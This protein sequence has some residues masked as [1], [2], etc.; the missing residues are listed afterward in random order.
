MITC[1]TCSKL[2]DR[3]AR[4]PYDQE[5]ESCRTKHLHREERVRSICA[6]FLILF[7]LLVLALSV[8]PTLIKTIAFL[9]YILS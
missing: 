8:L 1:L 2:M 3:Y 9:K 4:L 5:C 6:L 7:L